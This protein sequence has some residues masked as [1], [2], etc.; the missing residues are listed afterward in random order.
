MFTLFLFTVAPQ[1]RPVPQ[2]GRLVV[3]QGEAAT[4]GCDILR[5]NPTPEIKWRRKVK[6]LFLS[7]TKLCDLNNFALTH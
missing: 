2:N 4:L 5:G 3:Y 6:Q 7:A 1:I